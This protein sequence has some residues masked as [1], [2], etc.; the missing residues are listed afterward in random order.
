MPWQPTHMAIFSLSRFII[1]FDFLRVHGA[2]THHQTRHQN[3]RPD[4]F[5]RVRC[6]NREVAK[7][8]TDGD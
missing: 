5:V 4:D 3:H 2:Q 7:E 8:V 6:D 1:T